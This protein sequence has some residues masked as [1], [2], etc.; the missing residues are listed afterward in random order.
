MAL[1]TV[2]VA[3]TPVLL[4]VEGG[5]AVCLPHVVESSEPDDVGRDGLLDRGDGSLLV[6]DARNG[7]TVGVTLSGPA[8]LG[9]PGVL[10]TADT[11]N[12]L[13]L[14]KEPRTRVLSGDTAIEEGVRVDSDVIGGAAELGV[15]NH[16]NKSVDSDDAARVASSLESGS[17]RSDLASDV[18]GSDLATVDHLV[19][20]RNGIKS[21]PV[22]VGGIRH[23]LELLGERIGIPDVV[24]TGKKLEIVVVGGAENSGDLVAVGTVDTDKGPVVTVALSE[25]VDLG[26]VAVDIILG[27]AA[28]VSVVRRVDNT[29]ARRTLAAGGRRGRR[30]SSRRRSDLGAG[31][32]GLSGG[33]LRGLGRVDR[34]K[35]SG[36]HVDGGGGR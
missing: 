10:A 12:A 2:L 21:G 9:D 17:G 5:G 35:G 11:G 23:E 32:G 20:D 13:H 18:T 28:V 36:G 33:D 6:L 7:D 24:D 22:T 19:T 25:R 26:E 3:D 4:S 34:G 29:V 15:G 16:S 27:L 8:G 31:S 14:L 1:C 30:G